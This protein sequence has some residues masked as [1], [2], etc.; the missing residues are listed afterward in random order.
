MADFRNADDSRGLTVDPPPPPSHRGRPVFPSG[1]GVEATDNQGSENS[2]PLSPQWLFSKSVDNKEL[3]SIHDNK[4]DDV[5]ASVTV[6]GYVSTGKKKEAFR[7]ILHDP[8]GGR[9]D[10]WHDE[11]RETNSAIRRDHWRE[12]DK[13]LGD[14]HRTERWPENNSK[15]SGET[16]TDLR[17]ESKWSTRWGPSDKESDNW[18][19][20][21]L[22]S[23]KGSNAAPDKTSSYFTSH[24]KD[25][26]NHGKD[27]EGDDHYSRSWRS[28]Y[29][30]GRGRGDS[31]YNQSQTP[32]KQPNMH[33]YSRGRVENGISSM[34][35]G[36][37]KS[38]F[39]TNNKN[40]DTSRVHLVGSFHEKFDDTSGDLSSKRYTR[41][42]MLDIYRKT[43]IK[44]IRSSFDEFVGVPS[45]T[46]VET[47]E[48]LAFSAPTADESVIIKGID[49]GDIVS[50]GVPQL[51]KESS[52]GRSTPEAVPA[53]QSK[54]DSKYDLPNAVDIYRAQIDNSMME[55]CIP[56]ESPPYD[57]QQYQLRNYTMLDTTLSRSQSNSKDL[58]IVSTNADEMIS[59]DSSRF[60][61]TSSF[62]PQRSQ[63]S[64]DYKSGP[65]YGSNAFSSEVSLEHMRPSHLQKDIE[66]NTDGVGVHS[67]AKSHSSMNRQPSELTKEAYSFMS[68]D[69]LVGR[70]LHPPSP[71]DLLLYYKD[72]Q[73]QIQGPFSGSDVISWFEAGYFGIDLQVCLANS[74]ADA[75]FSSLGDVMPHLRAKAGPPPGFGMA[76][77]VSTV[78]ST[79]KGK[80]PGPSSILTG[81]SEYEQRD[82]SIAAA[83]TQN[84]FLESLMSDNNSS[85]ASETFSFN[86][87]LPGVVGESG[88]ETN[89]LLTQTRLL[90]RQRS[91]M[92]PVSYWSGGDSS[93]APGPKTDLV[94][95]SSPYS[96]LFPSTV[97][98]PVQ[99][100]KP[101][102][103]DLLSLLQAGADKAVSRTGGYGAS[104][105]SNFS[106]AATGNNPLHAGTEHQAEVLSMHYNQHLPS[107][108]RFGGQQHSFQPVN[109]SS[110]PNLISQHSD[111]SFIPPD[112]FLPS[113]MH[114]DP[115]LLSLSQQQYLL[116]Q[117]HLQSQIPAAQLPVLEKLLLLQQQQKQEQQQFMIQQQQQQQQ[118]YQ[119]MLS[120]VLSSH[121][122]Q[123]Q[124][125]GPYVQTSVAMPTGKIATDHVVLQRGNEQLQIGQQMPV[126]YEGSRASYHPN[127]NLQSS[128]NVNSPT[129]V[130]LSIP[131]PHHILDQGITSNESDTQFVMDNVATLP[132]T[133][134]KQEMADDLN[135]SETRGESE[136]SGLE[137]QNMTQSLSGTE[138]EQEVPQVSQAQDIAPLGLEDSRLST[139]F[140]PPMTDPVHDI[141]IS[142]LD[143]SDQNDQA[144]PN[145]V[146]E[147]Q[148]VKKN[149]EKKSKKQKKSK[150]KIVVDAGKGLP[151]FISSK[152]SN[153]DTEV[154][155]N[156]NEAKSE[157]LTDV[158]LACTSEMSEPQ[159][160][161]LAFNVNPLPSGTKDEEANA[162]VV[163]TPGSNLK[164]SSTQWAWKSA[165]GF[166]PKSLLEI[167]QEEQLKAQRG[168]SSETVAVTPA[169]VV[170]SPA[171]WS[172]IS[173][174]E[175]KPSSDTVLESNTLLVNSE[176]PLKSKGRKSNLHDLLAEEVLAKSNKDIRASAGNAQSSLLPLLSPG[177]A[178]LEASAVDDN[179]FVEA[180]DT[181]KARKKVSKSKAAGAKIQQPVG[182]AELAASPSTVEKD[183]ITRQVQGKESLPAPPAAPSLGDF[184]LWKEDQ[185][186]SVPPPAWSFDSKKQQRPVSLRDIQMEQQKRS[187]TMQQQQ[188]PISTAKV[189][190]NQ[191]SR[192]SG[193]WQISGTSPSNIASSHQFVPQV[194]NLI[195]PR[196]EDD[197]FW[198]LPEQS[199]PELKRPDFPPT[200]SS[201][202]RAAKGKGVS[203]AGTGQ[204][205]GS[206]GLDY[207]LSSPL[208]ILKGRGVSSKNSEAMEFQDWCVNEWIRLTGTNDTSFLEFCIKQTTSEAEMLLR[209]NI[210]S[211][212]H[213]HDFIDKF[214]NYKEFLPSDVLD[215]AFE[216]Q[217]THPISVEDYSH[218]N[219]NAVAA[220]AVPDPDE[221]T[222]D[223]FDGQPKG[224]GKKKGKKAQKVSS[225]LLG[226]NVV[227]NRIMMGEIQTLED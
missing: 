214:L 98:S 106:D 26:N 23:S 165:P 182:S 84:R 122:S 168:I 155:V 195:K 118:Q 92:N 12:G 49:K 113:E 136:K 112:K 198:G 46:Q 62:V 48:P 193:T 130:P 187:G 69:V 4:T 53:R 211:L 66:S 68:K 55:N 80:F 137:S 18:R 204:K 7:P 188:A 111:P 119:Q 135:F 161:S 226:F 70:K 140:A 125:G 186:S 162:N 163:A 153:V 107:Q 17:R 129:S 220:A 190:P 90:E 128:L 192:G 104:F 67:D 101:Q 42:K 97:D 19:G 208:P 219:S 160:P 37:G 227:S 179:D 172:S 30:L 120:N 103:V 152:A 61:A 221:G 96:K 85:S 217:K 123:Q 77:H 47:L 197:L 184:V 25:M 38:N 16:R 1:L 3:G 75:P 203:G 212:D 210:G 159:S 196:T 149:S 178:N 57:K 191:A 224:R 109:Q 15:H 78:D 8:E 183:K 173:N 167:Q 150:A 166:K 41:I 58:D 207:T 88:S 169:K 157:V 181:R 170:P 63:S 199:K 99:T 171:P 33:G 29:G 209:E 205:V 89:Y 206:R 124:F 50:S 94:S 28:N 20:K 34:F 133:K 71:E 143:L 11:E 185:S 10:R 108:I 115:R 35:V 56:S 105:L 21:W 141:N 76:K 138:K 93:S 154:G 74:P 13:E 156:A 144:V 216:L 72:P 202:S 148:E 180:K 174:F 177:Q 79:P 194:S 40:S 64:G 215:T 201:V 139:D 65:V 14:T 27:T 222:D 164:V 225:T 2:I 176:D 213:N 44:S 86:R 52:I 117:L 218:R 43:D 81:L 87:G 24:G 147:T 95:D 32:L 60:V 116:S 127:T 36:R 5:K 134:T 59:K 73:G 39:G 131:F 6:D 158:S 22:E 175:N 9:R 126:A 54:L 142:S 151:I 100:L 114:Q 102:Q 146:V 91:L 121:L 145:K 51:S 200:E 223:A 83:E 82:L 189:Q 45:L 31:N 132:D 110:L